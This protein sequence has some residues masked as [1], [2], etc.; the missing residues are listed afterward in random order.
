MTQLPDP[1]VTGPTESPSVVVELVGLLLARSFV[2]RNSLIFSQGY[3]TCQDF[4][5]DSSQT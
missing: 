4:A 5:L 1:A 2:Y 3:Y